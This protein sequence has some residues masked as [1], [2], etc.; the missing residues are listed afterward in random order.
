[1]GHDGGEGK[2]AEGALARS[3][4][5]LGLGLGSPGGGSTPKKRSPSATAG[6]GGDGKDAELG[7]R[8]TSPKSPKAGSS[9]TSGSDSKLAGEPRPLLQMAA[10]ILAPISGAGALAGAGASPASLSHSGHL[11]AGSNFNAARAA[12]AAGAGKL[13]PGSGASV[14]PSFF[15]RGEGGR[16]RGRRVAGDALESRLPAIIDLFRRHSI[17]PVPP[18]PQARRVGGGGGGASVAASAAGVART[19]SGRALGEADV[20]P[21][22]VTVDVAGVNLSWE[23][24]H[25]GIPVE[26]FAAVAKTL[27]GFPS[28]FAAPLYRRVRTSYRLSHVTDADLPREVLDATAASPAARAIALNS[29]FKVP[30]PQEALAVPANWVPGAAAASASAPGGRA[31]SNSTTSTASAGPGDADPNA[32]PL[33]LPLRYVETPPAADD[34]NDRCAC[35]RLRLVACCSRDAAALSPLAPR[36]DTTGYIALPTFL[37]Y[38]RC[39]IE[40]YDAVDRFFR[41]VKRRSGVAIEPA[42]FMPYMEE[43]LAFHP[44][45]AFLESTPEFQEK[46]ARTVI[47]RIFYVLDPTAKKCIDQ[48]QLRR[49]ALLPSFHMVDVEEDINVVNDYFRC[50]R[51]SLGGRACD[52]GWAT[53]VRMLYHAALAHAAATS[54]STSCTAS[55]GSWTAIT[56]SSCHAATSPS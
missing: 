35:G 25:L 37:H 54:T 40:P 6:G 33:R 5:K 55:S 1:M 20:V 48:R 43:L 31:R 27:C 49:S 15:V 41:L 47:A 2:E 19:K 29:L 36:R 26:H 17:A 45:L 39:E 30:I 4:G 14:I 23:E 9:P 10:D 46:Y 32:Y 21:T 50:A 3:P 38:W 53:G 52:C 51:L 7:G 8:A 12:A 22:A 13:V 44:G 16:G 28:F 56:T 24:A 42:D 18:A 34:P 11:R